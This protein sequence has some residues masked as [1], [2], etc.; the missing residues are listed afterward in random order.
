MKKLK[1]MLVALLNEGL[2]RHKL[3]LALSIGSVIGFFPI[4]G[5]TTLLNGLV[6]LK[7]RLNMA[8]IQL[9]NYL[10]YPMQFLLIIPEIRLAH[11]L[12]FDQIELAKLN[13]F[14]QAAKHLDAA[15]FEQ[16]GS[17][18]LMALVGWTLISIP[19]GLVIYAMSYFSFDVIMKKI[20]GFQNN[21]KALN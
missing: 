7:F 15:F 19:A 18:I 16:F 6:A 8:A 10:V 17:Y 20:K 11:V 21:E 14:M 4:L 2:S 9:M 1:Q 3:S 12:F 5:T 13:I